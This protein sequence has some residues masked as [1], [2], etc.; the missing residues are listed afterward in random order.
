MAQSELKFRTDN[1]D[2]ANE[3]ARLV[4]DELSKID[5]SKTLLK[6]VAE[7]SQAASA[8]LSYVPCPVPL[9]G[10][11]RSIASFANFANDIWIK[12]DKILADR[13]VSLATKELEKATKAATAASTKATEKRK[14]AS[15]YE[16]EGDGFPHGSLELLPAP[17]GQHGREQV[18]ALGCGA[19][20]GG[21][22]GHHRH[23]VDCCARHV[24]PAVG[25]GAC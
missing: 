16:Q 20:A 2:L 4:K 22:E 21:Q 15:D 18:G 9:P 17:C 25:Q 7:T 19:G 11:A 14:E 3:L 6:R 5:P 23:P 1:L 12:K 8:F 10:I 13:V 24:R